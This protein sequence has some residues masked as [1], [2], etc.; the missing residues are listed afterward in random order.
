MND[1]VRKRLVRLFTYFNNKPETFA[2]YMIKYSAFSSSF[3]KRISKSKRLNHFEIL[4]PAEIQ[5]IEELKILY[6]E[7][8]D[9]SEDDSLEQALAYAI[10]NEDFE[11][12]I[13]IRDKLK[14]I[15]K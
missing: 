14:K 11:M 13:I 1:D 2:E 6:A 12:A 15:K 8:F 7:L 4:D 3:I 9:D 5:T 10:E